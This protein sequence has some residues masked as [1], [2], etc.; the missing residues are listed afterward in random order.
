MVLKS[1]RSIM[2]STTEVRSRWE[3]PR[4]LGEAVFKEAAVGQAGE[5]D[6]GAPATHWK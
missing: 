3:R 1:S 4:A 6:R 2:M 5:A